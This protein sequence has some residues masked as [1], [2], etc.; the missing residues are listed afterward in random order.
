MVGMEFLGFGFW[1]HSCSKGT[2]VYMAIEVQE[3]CYKVY[4]PPKDNLKPIH[5][6][7]PLHPVEPIF[8]HNYLHNIESLF[9][10][11]LHTLFSTVPAASTTVPPA[12]CKPQRQFLNHIFPYCLDSGPACHD[13]LVTA[14]FLE[15]AVDLPLDYQRNLEQF[16]FLWLVLVFRFKQAYNDEPRLLWQRQHQLR[17]RLGELT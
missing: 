14:N 1:V 2:L 8:L 4:I 10:I 17:M 5:G 6:Q 16:V 12:P 7:P 3:A 11:G 15:A 9:W 13:L